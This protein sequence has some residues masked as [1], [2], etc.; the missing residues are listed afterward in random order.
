MSCRALTAACALFLGAS[1]CAGDQFDALGHDPDGAAGNDGDSHDAAATDAGQGGSDGGSRDAISADRREVGSDGGSFDSRGPDAGEGGR[2]ATLSDS[3]EGGSD[4]TSQDATIADRMPGDTLPSDSVDVGV[5]IDG[6][7]SPD[8][9]AGDARSDAGPTEAAPPDA[10]SMPWCAGK[11]FAFCADFD[12][13][14]AWSDGW[15]AA[16]VT[17]GALLEFNLVDFTSPRRS[18]RSRIPAGGGTEKAS[19]SVTRVVST[20]LSRSVIEFDCNVTSLGAGPGQWLVQMARLARN[21]GESAVALNAMDMGR[22]GVLV[23]TNLPVLNGELPAPPPYGRFVHVLL[24]VVWSATAGSVSVQFD[25]VTVFTRDA[26]TTAV[27]PAT[28]TVEASVGVVEAIGT[29][30]AAEISVDNVGL[31]LR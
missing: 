26:V 6:T 21:G 13:V 14:T 10:A 31:Q 20:T 9:D 1:A 7:L 15:T 16:N 5:A 2:D 23:T 19:A 8:R 30:P 12:T 25:G 28:S 4:G 22:W 3:G 24:D 27:T 17:P 18:L 29:T 11:Q